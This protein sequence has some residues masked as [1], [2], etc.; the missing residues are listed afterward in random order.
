MNYIHHYTSPLGKI[1]MASDGTALTGLWFEGQ[2]YLDA[3][4]IE[5]CPKKNLPV[6]DQ[7]LQWLELYFSGNVPGFTPPVSMNATPFR[8]TVWNILLTI[9]FGKTITY[10]EIASQIAAQRGLMQMS[11]QAVGGAVGHNPISLIIPCHR[12]IGANGSL[13]GYAGG[14]ERKRQLLTME[15]QLFDMERRK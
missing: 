8:K 3:A 11:A 10:G 15:K 7:T 14:L 6:F 13:T 1:I 9:P 5:N 12:V 4:L 2:K